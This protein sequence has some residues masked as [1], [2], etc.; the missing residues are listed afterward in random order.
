MVGERRDLVF[1]TDPSVAL[2][3]VAADVF[4]GGDDATAIVPRDATVRLS[5]FEPRW[6]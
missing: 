5:P 1:R 2:T 3:G 4:Y 6:R